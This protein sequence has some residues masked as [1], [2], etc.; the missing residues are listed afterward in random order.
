MKAT[1]NRASSTVIR[2]KGHQG[3]S[4]SGDVIAIIDFETKE[5]TLVGTSQQDFHHLPS[6][7]IRRQD[8]LRV[9][10]G[11]NEGS[12]ATPTRWLLER[13]AEAKRL[14]G[15]EAGAD[16]DLKRASDLPPSPPR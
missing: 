3:Y 6:I 9:A 7:R 2:M 11:T 8:R 4:A 15:D 12:T 10:S 14:S 5:L 16:E 1:Q 13:R